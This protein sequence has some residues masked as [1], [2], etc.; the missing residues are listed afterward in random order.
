MTSPWEEG[1][2]DT[3]ICI[4]G[5]APAK[6][7]MR[8]GKPFVGPAGKI[9]TELLHFAGLTRRDCFITNLSR[10][11]VASEKELITKHGLTEYGQECKD[12]LH[13]R[14]EGCQANT[15]VP[16]GNSALCA[17]TGLQAI[18]KWRGSPLHGSE[19]HDREFIPSIHPAAT[20][21]H[22]GP[23]IW[24]Y[25]IISDL[26]KVKRHSKRPGVQVPQRELI[27]DASLED[28]LGFISGVHKAGVCSF[29]LEI[30]NNQVSCFSL[31]S[32]SNLVMSIPM[33]NTWA[34][35][36]EAQIWQA[37]AELMYDETVVKIGQNHTSFDI[38]F[39]YLQNRIRTR[40]QLH[41]C[42][43]AARIMYPDFRSGLDYLTSVHTDEPYYKDDR[44]IW[45]R[46][47]DFNLLLKYCAKD[48]ATAQ[49]IWEVQEPELRADPAYSQDYDETVA[50]TDPCLAMSA[51]GM[52]M[53][54]EGL[55]KTN[56]EISKQIE[57][58]ESD[59]AACSDVPF[60]WSSS[61]QVINYFYVVKDIKA[62]IN[63]KTKKP[64]ADDKAL[65]RIVRR[66]N[67]PEA[68]LVQQLR[69]LGKLQGTYIKIEPDRDGRLRC[70]WNIRGT[71]TGR[72]SSSKT[73]FDTGMNM[74]NL[75]PRFK[76]F[77]PADPGHLIAEID[78]SGAEWVVTAY[79]AR[80]ERMME[81]AE[82]GL[83]PHL[84]TGSLISGAP[85]DFIDFEGD[86][87]GHASDPDE[88]TILR[89]ELPREWEEIPIKNFFFP[90]SMSIRQAGKKSNHGLNYNE[91]YRRFALENGM[92]EKDALRCY[93]GYHA[94]YPG[95]ALMYE[96][97]K[98]QL[99]QDRTLTNCFGQKRRFLD[100]W[101]EDLFNSAYAQIPQSTVVWI[102]KKAIKDCYAHRLLQDIWA[103]A[104]VHDSNV[105]S[106]PLMPWD[107]M[108]VAMKAI[109]QT[110]NI[111]MEYHGRT[112]TLK[113]SWKI[114]PVW[115][116]KHMTEVSQV[117]DIAE[118]L[119]TA[120]IQGGGGGKEVP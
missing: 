79:Y 30:F 100:Q 94:A 97:I 45:K 105:F 26:K 80:D 111:P 117:G 18:T 55:A 59:L 64:T 96:H 67:F 53:D 85:E 17:T 74:Q 49:D 23:Y 99:R 62:Y 33:Y 34:A 90:R 6:D 120:W 84:R 25:S 39:L 61:K 15:F 78:L 52:R 76:K 38:P 86:L 42:M 36:K 46:I 71:D 24:R 116:D 92:D 32:E 88:I 13:K 40:G 110:F 1:S 91:K 115:D 68:R 43:V 16:L 98:N 11:P 12:D 41:D 104:H 82:Q 3:K 31:C 65:A 47:Q 118:N 54:H 5:E 73:V 101:G 19:F 60:S 28:V 37:F 56:T 112:F 50:L 10:T 27:I 108:A 119:K 58:L 89:K 83:D 109:D 107:S 93:D 106:I 103:L 7:E 69:S 14:L 75:D 22:R 35:Y 51:K 102:T 2:K 21:P 4:I 114:G 77:L 95:L 20:L 8:L 44:K 70:A 87:L 81:V 48:S 113:R 66:Y 9:L 72:L 57:Q 63:L 29:D